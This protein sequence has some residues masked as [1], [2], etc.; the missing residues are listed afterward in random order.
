MYFTE[1]SELENKATDEILKPKGKEVKRGPDLHSF[2]W[3]SEEFLPEGLNQPT[4]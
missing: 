3:H 1:Y 2:E 4:S